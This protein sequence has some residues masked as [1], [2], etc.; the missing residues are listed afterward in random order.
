MN[1]APPQDS[2][3]DLIFDHL[4]EEQPEALE[5]LSDSEIRRRITLGIQKARVYG[6]ESLGPV[7]AFVTLLFLVDPA[8][9]HQPNIA[10]VLSD[11]TLPPDQRMKRLF[12]L[13][14]EEDWDAAASQ[15]SPWPS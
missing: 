10:R 4:C 5:G 7:T 9:D 2:L 15:S 6:L 1:P 12:S 14:K 11:T 8:F 3:D 13:T